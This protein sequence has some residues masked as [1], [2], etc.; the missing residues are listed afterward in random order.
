MMLNKIRV[1]FKTNIKTFLSIS[2]A[3]SMCSTNFFIHF[4]SIFYV[5]YKLF[6]PFLQHILRVLQTFLSISAAYSTCST[7]FFIHFRSIFYVFYEQYLTIVRDGFI[8]LSL[9]IFAIFVV[10]V[11]LL[12]FEVYA[13]IIIVI[14]IV[15][16]IIDMLGMMY[17]WGIPM[18]A[19]ALVNLVMVRFLIPAGAPQ[20]V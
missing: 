10:S 5:F 12:G 4:C 13:A 18:N 1:F 17:L 20:L 14:T 11:V 19:L 8:N 6:Y 15:F 3:Y 16:I 9:T 2:A 7:N